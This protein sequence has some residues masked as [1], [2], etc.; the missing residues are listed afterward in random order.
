M[1]RGHLIGYQF[2]GVNDE[3]KNLVPMTACLN[4]GNYK[5][6]DEGNQSGMLY[7]ENRLDNWLALHP[8]YWLDYKVTAIYSGDELLPRQVELQYVGID[9]SGNLLEIKLGGDK[10]TLDSQGVTHVILVNQSPNAEIN[11]AD[12]TATNTVTEFTEAPSEPSSESSQVTEQPSS[13]PEPVQPAQEESR[14]V[15]VARHGTADVYWYDIN[16][17]PSNTNK[18]NVVTMTEADALAQGKRHTSKE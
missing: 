5:G 15:Y 2:S 4:S 1:N 17:M 9:S 8:N 18:A 6:T 12:G 10:E 7:Y 11:Y 13:E 14:T 16:S 3:G